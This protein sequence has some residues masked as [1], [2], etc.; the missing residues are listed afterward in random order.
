[1]G[2]RKLYEKEF[3]ITIP[4]DYDIHHIDFDHSNNDIS[5]LLL[6]PHILHIALH[7]FV[8][9]YGEMI[10]NDNG[11]FQIDTQVGANITARMYSQYAVLWK[12]LE[13]WIAAKEHEIQGIKTSFNY[14]RF[15]NEF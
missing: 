6:I 9:Q 5:N 13:S 10:N 4:S 2:Y 8:N 11:K 14:N 15:R 1:M 7:T 3:N 12:R